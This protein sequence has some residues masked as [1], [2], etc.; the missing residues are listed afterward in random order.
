M[1]VTQRARRAGA[2]AA[3]ARPVGPVF[4]CAA[5]LTTGVT[6]LVVLGADRLATVVGLASGVLTFV[7]IVMLAFG[8]E[9]G[10]AGAGERAPSPGAQV[11]LCVSA[12]CAWAQ[13][14]GLLLG[15]RAEVGIGPVP[16]TTAVGGAGAL[17]MLAAAI[18]MARSG[19][20]R[21]APAQ[22]IAGLVVIALG[23]LVADAAMAAQPVLL[24]TPSVPAT[25]IHGGVLVSA[26][27][28]LLVGSG[29]PSRRRDRASAG[30]PGSA[31][32]VPG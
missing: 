32:R 13:T 17:S 5:V 31:R 1:A 2:V 20:R 7:A 22:V 21:R 9:D 28:Q 24:L 19:D 14:M 15:G 25:A 8:D 10:D 3:G 11:L 4:V 26:A 18:V 12:A 29:L 6:L 16:W 23:A 27:G 30:D